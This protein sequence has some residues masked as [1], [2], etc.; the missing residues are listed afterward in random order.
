MKYPSK[1]L[2][3]ISEV[4]DWLGVSKSWVYEHVKDNSFPQP[5]IL[6]QDDGTR[7]ASR[8]VREEI[9]VWLDARPRGVQTDAE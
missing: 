6:G 7:S 1:N 9:Q 5:V 2:L 4:T 3:R 8:W